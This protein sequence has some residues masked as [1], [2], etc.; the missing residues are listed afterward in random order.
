MEF[1]NENISQILEVFNFYFK[2]D[3]NN[4]NTLI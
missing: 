3:E 4:N 2:Y 1:N